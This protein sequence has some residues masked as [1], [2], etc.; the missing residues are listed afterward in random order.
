VHTAPLLHILPPPLSSF[1]TLASLVQRKSRAS[2][3]AT[4]LKLI[5]I[6][7]A[8]K[9]Q[10]QES[11]DR[12]LKDDARQ[13]VS[14]N[15]IDTP[16]GSVQDTKQTLQEH[17][18]LE[19]QSSGGMESALASA[20]EAQLD[21]LVLSTD[22]SLPSSRLTNAS[23][24]TTAFGSDPEEDLE[25]RLG[26]LMSKKILDDDEADEVKNIIRKMGLGG[27]L[28]VAGEETVTVK[29]LKLVP[30]SQAMSMA[31]L[32]RKKNAAKSKRVRPSQPGIAELEGE[33]RYG[34]EVVEMSLEAMLDERIMSTHIS[35]PQSTRSAGGSAKSVTG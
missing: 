35:R 10:Y 26:V 4:E 19:R 34:E 20:C 3:K 32:Q 13:Q 22:I 17:L 7:E 6:D 9:R 21:S 14:L 24:I 33:G 12:S 16:L 31:T 1:L 23:T 27:G 18:F 5:S 8:V 15:F 30:I 28:T 11:S 2:S 29:E 25:E